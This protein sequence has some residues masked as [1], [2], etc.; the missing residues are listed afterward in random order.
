MSCGWI[1]VPYQV[2]NVQR[3]ILDQVLLRIQQD[4]NKQLYLSICGEIH[5]R[6]LIDDVEYMLLKQSCLWLDFVMFFDTYI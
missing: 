2:I 6:Q 3:G 4:T 1:T 5:I